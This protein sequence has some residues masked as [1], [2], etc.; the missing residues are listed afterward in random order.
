MKYILLCI[1]FVLFGCSTTSSHKEYSYIEDF[2]GITT[3]FTVD[4]NGE[5]TGEIIAV[6]VNGDGITDEEDINLFLEA[7]KGMPGVTLTREDGTPI[8]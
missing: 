3:R 7:L 4:K 8:Q 5:K 2:G 6:D 1:I